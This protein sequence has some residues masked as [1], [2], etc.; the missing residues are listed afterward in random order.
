MSPTEFNRCCANFGKLLSGSLPRGAYVVSVIVHPLL[1]IIVPLIFGCFTR[2]EKREKIDAPRTVEIIGYSE[3]E[4]Q[5][6]EAWYRHLRQTWKPRLILHE[7]GITCEDYTTAKQRL[8]FRK[9][10]ISAPPLNLQP[11]LPL[12]QRHVEVE[13][14][15]DVFLVYD[16]DSCRDAPRTVEIIGYSEIEEQGREA[17]YRH[18]RQTW[19]PRLI[20]HENSITC[21]DYT[22][23]KQR[24][25]FRKH[26]ISAPPLNLQ[27]PL[28]L[29]QR[30]VE[31]EDVCDVFLV[32]DDDSCR[33]QPDEDE[34]TQDYPEQLLK[35]LKTTNKPPKKKAEQRERDD[36]NPEPIAGTQKVVAG[37]FP[38]AEND[39]EAS[40]ASLSE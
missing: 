4:E 28:P 5:G 16:D 14:V 11:P 18:L 12:A 19:K 35:P 40:N 25:K 9:H 36:G 37:V 26:P 7:N 8:K 39:M 1:A 30:H 15:C 31:V 38:N 34:L 3:I 29:A 10:P 27:P 2:M 21:E 13:D 6:R 23:A 17:W 20:L 24:L 22:T 32:Y 33:D